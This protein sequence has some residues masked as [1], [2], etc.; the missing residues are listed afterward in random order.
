MLSFTVFLV[1][2]LMIRSVGVTLAGALFLWICASF[3]A[4]VK[5]GRQ[6]LKL[7]V[8]PFLLAA[9]AQGFWTHWASSRQFAEWPLPGYPASYLAQLK[10]KNG[11]H[12][13]LG[14][15]HLSD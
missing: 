1:S 14:A 2:S 7:F 15:A 10:V 4:N 6:R 13:E 8:I 12:P 5:T 3:V 9:S 11:E